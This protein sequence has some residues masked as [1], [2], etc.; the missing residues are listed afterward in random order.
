MVIMGGREAIFGTPCH[1]YISPKASWRVL[2]HN[3]LG[4]QQ[5]AVG[6]RRDQPTLWQMVEALE[7]LPL[8]RCWRPSSVT[9]IS[10]N[11][12]W[13][14]CRDGKVLGSVGDHCALC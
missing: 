4:L 11:L 10:A 14:D 7:L 1:N 13:V 9:L 12:L 6:Q 5:A 3:E 2:H 8:W